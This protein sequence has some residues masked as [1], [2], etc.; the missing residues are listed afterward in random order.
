MGV[1]I[2]GDTFTERDYARFRERLEQCLSELGRMLDRP[3]FGAGPVTIGAEL[4]CFLVDDAALPLP[5]NQAVRAAVADPRIALELNRFNLELNASPVALTRPDSRPFA[6]L[7][8]ELDLLLGRI[9][10][11]AR[12]QGG[13][14]ALIGILPTLSEAHLNPGVMTDAPRYRALNRGLRRRRRGPFR[15]RIAGEDPLD[16]AI[17]H[18]APEG[19]NTSFQIHLRVAPEDFTR[20]YN[21][22]QLALAPV[23]AVAANSPT[24]L[25]HRLWEETRI[26]LFKQC[27]EDRRAGPRRGPSRTTLGTGWLRGGPLELFTDSVRLHEPLLPAV[28]DCEPGRPG[29]QQAPPL[30]ELRLHLGTVW[31]WNRAVYDPAAGGHLRIEMRSLPAGPTVTDMMANAAFM[32]GLTLWLAGQDPRWTYALPFE[33]ADHGFYRAAQ[34]G[35]A[36]ELSWPLGPLPARGV[37]RGRAHLQVRALPAADLVAELIPAAR[38]GLLQAGVAGA[39]ADRLLGVIAARLATGQTGAAWQ[40]AALAAAAVGRTREQALA[41]MLDQYLACAATGQ[42]VHTWPLLD[43]LLPNGS[44][45]LTPR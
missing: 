15:I 21:A 45:F 44:W 9:G 37:R 43:Q 10:D 1:Q 6:A 2:S 4:E 35:L 19:A 20:T 14:I 17:E 27:V 39:E 18:V 5:R 42:P 3:G 22:A 25:G 30:D 24:F 23:L 34:Y 26:A 40:R 16:L 8:G 11:A 29:E 41:V 28:A 38:Q 36:A 33:R 31:R 13:R 12:A 7:G 32:I